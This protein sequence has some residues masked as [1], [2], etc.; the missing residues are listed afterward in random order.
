MDLTREDAP[1]LAQ[2]DGVPGREGAAPVEDHRVDRPRRRPPPRRLSGGSGSLQRHP[3]G[4][5]TDFLNAL[6]ISDLPRRILDWI[7]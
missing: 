2:V 7:E 5:D 6:L 1:L 4:I 3:G